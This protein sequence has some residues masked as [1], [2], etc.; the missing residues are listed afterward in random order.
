MKFPEKVS[1]GLSP[2]MKLVVEAIANI[3]G[4]SQ[5]EV[6]RAAI[7]TIYNQRTGVIDKE[8]QHIEHLHEMR[9]ER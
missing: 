1:L 4:K 9:E 3:D 8:I 6:I 2:R 7:A 5:Q